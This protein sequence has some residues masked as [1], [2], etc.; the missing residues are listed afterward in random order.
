MVPDNLTRCPKER[1]PL[2][3]SINPDVVRELLNEL[4]DIDE[5][6]RL[7]LSDGQ[8]GRDVSS[9]TEAVEQLY[10]DTGLSDLL[11]G[12]KPTGLGRELE[13]GLKELDHLL[14]EVNDNEAPSA[15][16]N[17]PKMSEVRILAAELMKRIR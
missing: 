11:E 10:G 9:F 4:S 17:D 8:N 1:E 3:Y 16:I 2:M 5:Q 7:W 13:S 6:R 12:G 15:V 14:R